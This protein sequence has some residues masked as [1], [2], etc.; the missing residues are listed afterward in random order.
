[1]P[2][3]CTAH[4]CC[5]SN[6]NDAHSHAV[7]RT[8]KC[9]ICLEEEI[10]NT[11]GVALGDCDDRLCI[12]CAINMLKF[13]VSEKGKV[14]VPCPTCEKPLDNAKCLAL[15]SKSRKH[16]KARDE[17]A[18]MVAHNSHARLR[19]CA[20]EKCGAPFDWVD[21][22]NALD[23][24]IQ[25]PLCWTYTCAECR[26][27]WHEQ[28][29]CSEAKRI[30]ADVAAIGN[31][32]IENRWMPCPKCHALIEKTEGCNHMI[33]LC[34]TSFCYWCGVEYLPDGRDCDCD[35]LDDEPD[36]LAENRLNHALTAG[37]RTAEAIAGPRREIPLRIRAAAGS[38]NGELNSSFRGVTTMSNGMF[39][40]NKCPYP[41]CQ[42]SFAT[43]DA[44]MQHLCSVQSHPVWICCGLLFRN[45]DDYCRHYHNT[46]N[47]FMHKSPKGRKAN[48][49][50][51][52]RCPRKQTALNWDDEDVYNFEDDYDLHIDEDYT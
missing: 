24:I 50:P 7:S 43:R 45:V 25:C 17:F 37:N 39:V 34:D 3:N 29:T 40:H 1:M 26:A 21:D 27:P 10:P 15:L 42:R 14:P 8:F 38:V 13:V 6:S 41:S 32:A 44:L 19:Y 9:V 16:A 35:L 12:G 23:A 2:K 33:C 46:E 11:S 4:D 49:K 22:P 52:H 48:P 51:G 36:D 18:E 31:L 5:A 47:H 28:W 20:N 30:R